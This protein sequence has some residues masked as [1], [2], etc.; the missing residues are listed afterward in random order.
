MVL[1]AIVAFICLLAIVRE[2]SFYLETLE[3]L[4]SNQSNDRFQ[5]ALASVMQN[6]FWEVRVEM[7]ETKGSNSK[8]KQGLDEKIKAGQIKC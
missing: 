4:R 7:N 2:L 6:R 8:W 1:S 5:P 3:I